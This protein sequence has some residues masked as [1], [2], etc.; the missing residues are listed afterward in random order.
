MKK[1]NVRL[2]ISVIF[3]PNTKA[4]FFKALTVLQNNQIQ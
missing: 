2:F 1:Y 4:T 3:S